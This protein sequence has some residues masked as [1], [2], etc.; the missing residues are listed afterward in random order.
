MRRLILV[1][2]RIISIFG[3]VAASPSRIRLCVSCEVRGQPD[4]RYP[5]GTTVSEPL[6]MVIGDK[7]Q[8]DP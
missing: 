6:S 8:R 5:R 4:F 1:Q 2:L 3:Q 7:C